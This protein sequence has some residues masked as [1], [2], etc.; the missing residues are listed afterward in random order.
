[1]KP[2]HLIA[3]IL[4]ALFSPAHA[5]QD[6]PLEILIVTSTRTAQPLRQS[7]SHSTVI[8]ERDIQFSQAAD[9]PSLLKNLAGIELY[10]SGGI[11]K[12]SSLFLRG[13]E[14][15]HVLILLDGVRINSATTGTTAI[16]QLMLDQIE[17]IEVVRGNVSSLYGSEA[18]GG[19]IQIFTKR[20]KGEPGLNVSGGV[21]SHNTQRLAGGFGGEAGGAWTAG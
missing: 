20:G 10:Q 16:D 12:Q 17:R 15:D 5:E 13:T 4:F 2:Q 11:G 19:V 8:T 21:G 7:L 9:V 1:M 6:S 14:S 3:A 18:I